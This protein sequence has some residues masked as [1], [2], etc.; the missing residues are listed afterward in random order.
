MFALKPSRGGKPVSTLKDSLYSFPHHIVSSVS[1]ITVIRWSPSLS[2]LLLR[3]FKRII[4][5]STVT[6][7]F[8]ISTVNKCIVRFCVAFSAGNV[9]A[10]NWWYFFLFYRPLDCVKYQYPFY[11]LFVSL[12]RLLISSE[13]LIAGWLVVNFLLVHLVFQFYGWQLSCPLLFPLGISLVLAILLKIAAISFASSFV[14]NVGSYTLISSLPAFLFLRWL[15]IVYL[16]LKMK[17][18]LRLAEE[19]GHVAFSFFELFF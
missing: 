1:S 12:D 19:Y 18:L 3:S 13:A 15:T 2:M 7:A 5:L 6:N 8:D 4:V 9:V 16:L 14:P 10:R 11:L 17:F